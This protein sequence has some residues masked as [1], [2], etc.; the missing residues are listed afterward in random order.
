MFSLF[1]KKNR[2]L[3]AACDGTVVPV[4][5]SSDE[6]F[7]SCMLGNGVMIHPQQGVVV[8]PC[9][10]EITVFMSDTKHAIGIRTEYGLEVMIHIG[11]DTVNLAGEGFTSDVS[12]GGHVKAGD[13]LITF[14]QALIE[15]KGYC[16]DVMEIVLNGA[17]FP[18]IEYQTGMKAEAGRTVVAVA[19]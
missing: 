19:K 2:E 14:D 7:A 8:A 5:E 11:I 9:T 12:Q 15:G 17:E 10:G 13:R 18:E 3:L 1:K 6:T 16:C 4:T